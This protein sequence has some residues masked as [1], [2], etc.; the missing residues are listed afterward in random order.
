MATPKER[1]YASKSLVLLLQALEG[2]QTT[3][4]LRNEMAVYGTISKVDSYMNIDMTNVVLTTPSSNG[5][6]MTPV[7]WESFFVQGRQIRYVHVPDDI[8]MVAVV[9]SEVKKLQKKRNPE[10]PKP[11]SIAVLKTRQLRQKIIKQRELR[12]AGESGGARSSGGGKG[13]P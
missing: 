13:K 12:L 11:V 10:D 3:V 1:A 9:Q 8:N 5:K 7:T 6:G 4:E 2:R